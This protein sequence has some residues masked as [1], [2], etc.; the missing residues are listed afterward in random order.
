MSYHGLGIL[1]NTDLAYAKNLANSHGGYGPVK[2]QLQAIVN[3]R[4]QTDPRWA[5]W[6]LLLQYHPVVKANP[7]AWLPSFANR[8]ELTDDPT[9]AEVTGANEQQLMAWQAPLNAS[10][11]ALLALAA[12]VPEVTNMNANML[13]DELGIN[14]ND[15][16]AAEMQTM[17]APG[18]PQPWATQGQ[19]PDPLQRVNMFRW[20]NE[21]IGIKNGTTAG[22]AAPFF[23]FPGSLRIAAMAAG[24]GDPVTLAC[25]Q[26]TSDAATNNYNPAATYGGVAASAVLPDSGGSTPL[27]Y[28]NACFTRSGGVIP[29]SSG[30]SSTLLLGAA[31]AA[32][33]WFLL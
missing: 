15:I 17:Q 4:A 24:A 22:A 21:A 33:L 32:G 18:V 26:G 27:A 1:T 13:S 5:V 3:A 8:I 16:W 20:A 6:Q 10:D 11:Q 31:L 7:S 23:S 9:L 14:Q 12:Q 30:S 19:S 2:A 28:Y 29:S 25:N